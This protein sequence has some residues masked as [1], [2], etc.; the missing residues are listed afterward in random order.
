MTKEWKLQGTL[1]HKKIKDISKLIPTA[2]LHISQPRESDLTPA[3]LMTSENAFNFR[4]LH[5]KIHQLEKVKIDD[6]HT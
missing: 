4:S 6:S 5:D 2:G 3:E 1:R